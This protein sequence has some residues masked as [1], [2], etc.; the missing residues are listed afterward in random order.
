M[1]TLIKIS[2]RNIWRNRQ[3][4]LTMIL[5]ITVGLWGG[6]FAASIATGL[7]DQRFKTGVEQEFSHIQVHNPEFLR[8][9]HPRHGIANWDTLQNELSAND[10]VVAFSGR[11]LVSGM[12]ASANMTQGVNLLGVNPQME[13]QTSSLK[14]NLKEGEYFKED[15]LN[16]LLLGKS[17]A[18]QMNVRIGSRLV[19][20]FQDLNNEL[21]STSCRVSGIYQTANSAFDQRNIYLLQTDLNNYLGDTT[22]VTQAAMLLKDHK[23]SDDFSDSLQK[24]HPE[25]NIR[26][27]AEV[28]PQLA[29]YNEM[30]MTMFMII[31]FIILLALAFGLLNTM[32]MSV[33]ERVKEL[34]MLMSIGMNKKRV[35][36]MILLET[37]F[38]SLSG[39]ASGMAASY[40]TLLSLK[41][42][43]INLAPLGAG[44]LSEF[45]FEPVVYPQLEV[46]F[47]I[48][49]T[50]MVV[51]AAILTGIYPALKALRLNP[52]EAVKAD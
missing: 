33:F 51:A 30:G 11:T 24:K 27:W 18:D 38:L 14:I 20:T 34:G 39:A 3:R 45:G 47:F 52:A 48:F 22:I 13:A 32:L 28:S 2:W 43:G 26:T 6:L 41:D 37:I 12:I 7:M 50:I 4:S 46:S 35:F 5:A 31:L 10:T 49:L 16:P 36:V 29:F 8:E 15:M 42:K 19:I 1:K 17:L 44:S 23:L 40:L 25:L 9:S 21:I